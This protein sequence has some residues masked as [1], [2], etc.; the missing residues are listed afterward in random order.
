VPA[1]QQL[2]IVI[3]LKPQGPALLNYAVKA[4]STP[5]SPSY[6]HF[7]GKGEFGPRYGA[8]ETAIAHVEAG[9]SALGL[10]PGEVASG[11]LQ[12][13]V[14]ADVAAAERAFRVTE[15]NYELP[16]GR[17]VFFPTSAPSLPSDIAPYVESVLGLD[18]VVVGRPA[19]RASR[20]PGL[21][22]AVAMRGEKGG[23]VMGPLSP[24]ACQPVAA[25][26]GETPSALADLYDLNSFYQTGDFGQ[27]TTIALFEEAD[28]DD[29]DVSTYQSCFRTSVKVSRVRLN[30]GAFGAPSVGG[31]TDEVTGD[32]EDIIGLAPKANIE[33]YE[34]AN[35]PGPMV[36]EYQQIAD[37]DNAQVVSTSW[38]LG[39]E[40]LGLGSFGLW[41]TGPYM[42]A[43]DQIFSQMALQGQT[44]LAAS[45]DM[46][47]EACGGTG[48]AVTYPASDPML[49]G[50]GG[51]QLGGAPPTE[52]VWNSAC[53]SGPC[54]GGGGISSVWHMPSWQ[55]ALGVPSSLS[56]GSPCGASP[57]LC[58][59][60]PDVSALAGNP[61]YLFFCTAGNC[62]PGG[63]SADHVGTSF[64]TP[65]W[66][67]IVALMDSA[68]PSSPEGFLNPLLYSDEG[69]LKDITLGDNNLAGGQNYVANVG[70]DM[71][72]GLGSPNGV[73]LCALVL[74]AKCDR[75]AINPCCTYNPAVV[76]QPYQATLTAEGGDPPYSGWQIT[77]SSAPGWLSLGPTSG[78]FTGTPTAPGS[79][80]FTVAVL[81]SVGDAASRVIELDVEPAPPP[82][83]TSL[84]PPYGPVAGG[85]RVT[86]NGTGFLGAP[87]SVPAVAFTAPGGAS[88]MA[89]KVACPT[90]AACTVTVP[91]SP[92]GGNGVG[93]VNV[94][95]TLAS[96]QQGTCASCFAYYLPSS[97]L[98]ATTTSCNGPASVVATVIGPSG[99]PLRGQLI[100]FMFSYSNGKN[101]TVVQATNALG[102]AGASPAQG[103]NYAGG[104][105]T[106]TVTNTSDP[107]STP[108]TL[109][110][111]Q[112]VV[113][114]CPVIAPPEVAFSVYPVMA[115]SGAV[116]PGPTGCLECAGDVSEVVW[117]RQLGVDPATSYF[118]MSL[119]TLSPV[120]AASAVSVVVEPTA[121]AASMVK[122]DHNVQFALPPGA[123]L[124]GTSF[125]GPVIS[126]SGPAALASVGAAPN[127]LLRATL[128]YNTA[129][130]PRGSQLEVMVLRTEEGHS[131]WSDAGV[132]TLS[133]AHGEISA[134]LPAFGLVTVAAVSST[135]KVS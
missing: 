55:K 69:L 62:S 53:T 7:L 129:A 110:V 37:D 3:I 113:L 22:P 11:D 95:A 130:V 90:G 2:A 133:A 98:V 83:V 28:F 16:G 123:H 80:M 120:A 43:E 12:L 9:L 84:F 109:T 10:K 73:G 72:S 66:A 114:P 52:M 50:V 56:S 111:D 54:G 27:G 1:Q 33:V 17:R 4:A 18:D 29:T 78:S 119:G 14:S 104:K 13:E 74:G 108:T 71:A 68:S 44:M 42:V 63:W 19:G 87:S 115:G 122:E 94:T 117:D 25:A 88:T 8:A 49:T 112:L 48:L 89:S 132:T 57:G 23:P 51:T 61:D 127:G 67:A 24:Q 118:A 81:D 35:L 77:G 79:Y 103:A 39:C 70:Y 59:E 106:V 75:L 41:L 45:G 93:E 31:G 40:S 97:P 21:G 124:T 20:S 100:S 85:T 126:T 60:V 91:T 121:T 30:I 58:R 99:S 65:L 6:K 92:L 34:A 135:S 82:L 96:G 32:I 86:M 46:G 76:G 26:G 102:V 131:Y 5:G 15:E 64:A 125:V 134:V 107:A 101:S 128:P 116:R 38:G 105:Y 47:S 36:D